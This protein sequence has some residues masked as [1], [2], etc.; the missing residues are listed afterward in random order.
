MKKLIAILGTFLVVGAAAPAPAV[1][2]D[3][4]QRF[5]QKMTRS[6]KAHHSRAYRDRDDDRRQAE[7]PPVRPAEPR[8]RGRRRRRR[9]PAPV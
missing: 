7:V 5:L 8:R 4:V 3:P 2:D 9:R 6:N 1:A